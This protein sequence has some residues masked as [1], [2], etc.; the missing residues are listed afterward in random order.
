[1]FGRSV[2]T[3]VLPYL[4]YTMRDFLPW[5]Q[6]AVPERLPVKPPK[7]CPKQHIMRRLR[8]R[9]LPGCPGCKISWGHRDSMKLKQA[10]TCYGGSARRCSGGACREPQAKGARRMAQGSSS[11]S[12]QSF[13]GQQGGGNPQKFCKAWQLLSSGS[14][15]LLGICMEFFF[16]LGRESWKLFILRQR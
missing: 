14:G 6:L 16:N 4:R 8:G 11:G 1:M 7:G 9:E 12:R 15:E 13:L 5:V 2:H 3:G 10:L